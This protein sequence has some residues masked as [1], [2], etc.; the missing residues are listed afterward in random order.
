MLLDP[1]LRSAWQAQAQALRGPVRG[2]I[3][4]CESGR[5]NRHDRAVYQGAEWSRVLQACLVAWAATDNPQHATTAIKF[6]TALLDDRDVIGDGQ[7]GDTSAQRDSGYA[8]RNLGPYTALA[9][10]WLHDA[11]G[12]TPE[13][14]QK[15]RQ[16]WAA[17]LRWYR[18]H[19][20]RAR[21][22]GSNYHAGFLASATLIAVAQGGEADEE[23]GPE[24]WKFVA[25]ELW[26]KDMV[27]ALAPGGILDGGDWPEGWQYGPLSVAHYAIAS[28]IARRA[29]I[30]V[31]GVD[32]WLAAVLRRH[33]YGLSPSNKVHVAQ[34]TQVETP[35]IDP[36]ALTLASIVLG[37]APAQE[38]RWAKG[39]LVR[40]A[41]TDKDYL[42]YS[43]LAAP[44][45]KP[46]LVPRSTWPTWYAAPATGTLFARTRWDDRAIWFVAECMLGLDIDHRHPKAG[47]F[48]LSRGTD[49]LIVDP[50][51]YGSRSTLTSNAPTVVSAHLPADYKPSQ[52]FWGEGPGWQWALQTRSGIVAARC[53]YAGA[54]R[55]QHRASDVP[56]AQRDFVLLPGQDGTDTALVVIDRARTGRKDRT[57]HLRFRVPGGLTLDDE[58]A[59]KRVGSSKLMIAN[60]ERTSG[61]PEIG[62]TSLTNCYDDSTPKGRCDAARFDATDLRLELEGPEPRAVHVITALDARGTSA[63]ST[64]LSGPTWRGVQ[65]TSPRPAAV[66]WPTRPAPTLAYRAPPGTHVILDGPAAAGAATI[67]ARR[68]GDACA[69]EVRA[70]GT[71]PAR[72]AIV[73]LDEKCA[74]SADPVS[75]TAASAAGTSARAVPTSGQRRTGCCGAQ[76]TPGSPI[77]MALLVGALVL[78]RRRRRSS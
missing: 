8:I 35:N 11:P 51:P 9:Y 72:P 24:L 34:D 45:D 53:D 60:L 56:S 37:D 75:E 15:A 43:A 78:R 40:L 32:R 76:A 21:D 39:E 69:V 23:R 25:D 65:I 71:V 77:A 58:I 10:D 1:E 67:T 30:E 47:N 6:F 28:R 52:G 68:D 57:M 38:K 3:A 50:S 2:S 19:G 12:M 55:F 22:P 4:L 13:L 49:D 62:R 16:R 74:I 5:T 14:R 61:H 29:G 33:V 70:G 48:V 59:T 31:P 46:E 17:W 44:G 26:G 7:G 42:L 20:Y 54:Y 18:E 73:V 41:I 27:K 63:P 36:H 64:P 66:V